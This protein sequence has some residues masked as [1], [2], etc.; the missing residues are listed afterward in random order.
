MNEWYDMVRGEG[1]KEGGRTGRVS[2]P[3]SVIQIRSCMRYI[4][5]KYPCMIPVPSCVC[6]MKSQRPSEPPSEMKPIL[7]FEVALEKV[8]VGPVSLVSYF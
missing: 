4:P 3:K 6:A 8:C 2:K 1:E 7:N 5:C